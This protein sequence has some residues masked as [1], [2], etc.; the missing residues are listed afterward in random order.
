ISV[1]EAVTKLPV[2]KLSICRM[3]GRG[4]PGS[5]GSGDIVVGSSVSTTLQEHIDPARRRPMKTYSSGE[6]RALRI[7]ILMDYR[8]QFPSMKSLDVGLNAFFS[9]S[10]SKTSAFSNKSF[11]AQK[12]VSDL[13]FRIVRS[14][15]PRERS[16]F[17]T[18]TKFSKPLRLSSR[19]LFKM[20]R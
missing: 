18:D 2:I 17:P 8:A 15:L 14:G 3:R 9:N 11:N 20:S 6:E 19:S 5:T 12:S 13:L 16:G 7:I 1:I 4:K 10:H